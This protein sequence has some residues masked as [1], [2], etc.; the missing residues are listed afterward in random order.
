MDD[1]SWENGN[2]HA[3]RRIDSLILAIEDAVDLLN[4]F[5]VRIDCETSLLF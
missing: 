4:C 5:K 2:L 3:N 1:L